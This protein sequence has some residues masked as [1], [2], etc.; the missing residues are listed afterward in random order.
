MKRQFLSNETYR[1]SKSGDLIKEKVLRIG[2]WQAVGIITSTFLA[3]VGGSLFVRFN[4]ALSL[5]GRVSAVETTTSSSAKDIAWIKESYMTKELAN[6]R[7][8]NV[9]RQFKEI[10]SRLDLIQGV[11]MSLK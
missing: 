6:E 3:G 10:L 7:T 4:V 1:Q 9:E 8:Q 11:L 5:P 2:L